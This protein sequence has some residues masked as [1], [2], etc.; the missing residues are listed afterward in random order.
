[1]ENFKELLN[2][3]ISQGSLK[4]KPTQDKLSIPLV[5]RIYK[6]MKAGLK[7][8]DAIKVAEGLIIDGHHRYVASII[9]GVEIEQFPSNTNL[10]QTYFEWGEIT[11]RTSEYDTD[12]QIKYHNFNDAK[13]NGMNIEDI[14]KILSN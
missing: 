12:I 2:Q 6:K 1:M 8:F 14:E 9:A 4:L 11:L 7:N 13:R 5:F 3:Q 10:N